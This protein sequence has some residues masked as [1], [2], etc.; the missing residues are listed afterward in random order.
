M[1]ASHLSCM[2]QETVSSFPKRRVVMAQDTE[3][4]YCTPRSTLALP[5][6][7]ELSE[8]SLPAPSII[9]T[10]PSFADAAAA[11]CSVGNTSARKRV[12]IPDSP[13]TPV[14]EQRRVLLLLPLSVFLRVS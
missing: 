13:V 11:S 14:T 9:R 12:F 4:D 1:P 5:D 10:T 6:V 2:H 7:P 8:M 3:S